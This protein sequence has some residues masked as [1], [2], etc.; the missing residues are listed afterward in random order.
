MC[1][2]LRIYLSGSIK[3][4]ASDPRSEVDF[5]NEEDEL[6]IKEK[7]VAECILLN[8]AKSSISR[9]DYFVNYGCDL[10]L[11]GS[12]DV[13]IADF[14]SS[15]GI[16]V[17]AELMYAQ[18]LGIPVIGWMPP[19]SYY[20][21]ERLEDVYGEDLEDWIHPF[22]Y[23]L[24]DFLVASIE[25]AC[26]LINAALSPMA[27]RLR[28]DPTKAPASA[29]RAYLETVKEGGHSGKGGYLL[30]RGDHLP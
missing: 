3:K 15:K 28:K 17:G 8:P 20:Y 27:P 11:V 2:P 9:N 4:G 12:A 25:G 18:T 22:V 23:G 21:R 14:R 19:T 26:E 24:S 30:R 5:W 1:L 10:Y 13:V 29:V 16:G 6:L 7:L